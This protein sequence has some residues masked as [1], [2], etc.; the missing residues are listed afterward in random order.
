MHFETTLRCIP[1]YVVFSDLEEDIAG[2]RAHDV[3][4]NVKDELRNSNPDFDLYN[5]VRRSG[6]AGLK[7][8]DFS[9]D[10]NTP[11][12]KPNNP[13]WKLDKWKFLPM[14]NETLQVRGDAAWYVFMEADTYIFWPNLMGWLAQ[15]DPNQPHYFGNQMQIGDVIFAHGGSG[16]VLSRAAMHRALEAYTSQVDQ[17]DAYTGYHWA[18]DCVL[19]KLL[20]DIGIKLLWAW[21]MLDSATPAEANYFVEG[22]FKLPW[23]Y[24]RVSYH[25]V[26][27]DDIRELW[28]FEHK[29]FDKHPDR[30]LLHG[31]LFL[32][33]IWKKMQRQLTD[34]DNLSDQLIPL[35]A[36][37]LT[38]CEN[39][40]VRDPECVQY[41]YVAGNCRTSKAPKLGEAKS[42]VTSD[43][44]PDRINGLVEKLGTCPQPNWVLS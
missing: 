36:P 35:D 2:V 5:R 24:P 12:G 38:A 17:W 28:K 23:C 32:G 13:G 3:L 25:H 19:G 6:R 11:S 1:H 20:H 27:P 18:G 7:Q 14:I 16:F 29:W 10:P 33:L 15:F 43:W 21:P 44:L 9:N 42:G 4:R 8:T 37:S 26:S 22:Y 34:W 31:D 39:H 40:C 30:F 41:S